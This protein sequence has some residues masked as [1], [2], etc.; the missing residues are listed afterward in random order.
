MLTS[1]EQHGTKAGREAVEVLIDMV[2][3]VY[4]ISHVGKCIVKT[5]LVVRGTTR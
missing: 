1:V 4:S 3:G 5:S 2:T